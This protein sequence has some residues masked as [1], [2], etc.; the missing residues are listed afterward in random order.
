MTTTAPAA[1][2]WDAWRA[3]YD[4]MTFAEQEDFYDRVFE[5]FPDQA[6]YS[7]RVLSSFLDEIAVPVDIVELG[8]WDGAFAAE[9][10][11][12]HKP[13]T[14][15]CNSEISVA[16]AEATVCDD[17]RYSLHVPLTDWYWTQPHQCDLF[18]ASHVIEHLKLLDVLASFDATGCRWMYL[19]APLEEEA[20]DWTGYRGSHIL[21]V[22][23]RVLTDEL[24]DRGF[25]FL[26]A[27]SEPFARCFE[28]AE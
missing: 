3:A 27:L 2:D 9:I 28:K 17:A 14:G 23:W 24:A 10:L 1:I 11:A 5:Q 16:A 20:T 7:V 26:P 4:T 8:G 22:G 21:E 19:Q 18:V 25:R 15:W 12:K 6:R 13:I